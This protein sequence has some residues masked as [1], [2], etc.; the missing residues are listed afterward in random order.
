MSKAPTKTVLKEVQDFRDCVKRVV[1]MLSGKQIPVAE[2]GNDAFVRYNK[3]GEP[4][5]VNIPSIPDDATPT[6]MNAVRGFL[7]HE[8]AH[9][10]FT[11]TLVAIKMRKKGKAPSAGL[12][13]ALEDVF[14]ERKMGQV[15][16]GTRRNLLATQNLI[17]DK[18]FKTKVPE[19]VSICH[20]NQRDLFLKFFLCPVVRAWDGQAPFIEFMEKYWHLI[21]KPVALLKEHGV[22]VAVR[23]MS[24]TE[25]C[26]KVAAAIA[27]LMK[28]MKENPEG[29][30]PK[31]KS[32]VKKSP[33][34]E[35]ETEVTTESP[36]ESSTE[37][38][39]AKDDRESTDDKKA[40]ED[41]NDGREEGS[42]TDDSGVSESSK[43]VDRD[44]PTDDKDI[45]DT[46]NNTT[47]AGADDLSTPAD[48]I[49]DDA[50]ISDGYGSDEDSDSTTGGTAGES[51][52]TGEKADDKFDE[53]SEKKEDTETTQ[54]GDSGL[55]P[56]TD[57][58]T[59][60]DALKAL[61]KMEDAV[62]EMTEDALSATISKELTSTSLSDYRPYDRSY[63]FIGSIDD[64]EGH[65]KRTQKVFGAIPLHYPIDRYRIVTEGSKLFERRIERYLSSG[66]SSTLAKDLERAIASRNRV[67]FI[68]G[69]RRGR[70]HGSSLYRLSMKDE[71]VFRRKE[72]HKAVNACVQQV[73]D[74][75]GS[76]NGKKILLALAS[77]YTIADALDR[78]NVPNII[79]GFTTFGNPDSSDRSKR[80]FSRFEALMLPIIKNWN[81]KANA[82]EIRAR[83][84]CVST[85]F[86]LLNNVDGESIVQL[87]SLFSGRTEDRK[88]MLVLSDGV[89]CATGE[90]FKE[91]LK[92]TTK[93]IET[94]SDIDLMAIGI[95]TDAPKFFYKNYA[96]VKSVEQLGSSV[97]TELS[98]I[99][100]S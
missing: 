87:A 79:T 70:I 34:S 27:T 68:P 54:E 36:E 8:V 10:L 85:T 50:D 2:R 1:A 9:I 26:V 25:D 89:P 12:W 81:E 83:M 19:A 23:N 55:T 22:D 33:K 98:R 71:R 73:I 42:E 29:E 58:M 51:E 7:D 5:L 88:I 60:E 15:F 99:I 61:D 31:L 32:S 28:D 94:V 95:L 82:P 43:S 39:K 48:G 59:L 66:V 38:V 74:L 72:D 44:L 93:E 52:E 21:A 86:P 67:Q 64:A 97:V 69:Q 96:L 100:L 13:N 77:A 92:A 84:G 41:R 24:S 37:R 53:G 16:N 56:T 18:Y 6:L 17:I 80:G 75:S 45:S 4:V 62:G 78:I 30:L 49:H 11:D 91:H 63:D 14:I 35:E 90:G 57:D 47:E 20:G 65:I 76:M 46:D 40:K 3:R